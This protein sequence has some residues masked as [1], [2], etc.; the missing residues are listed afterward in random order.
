MSTGQYSEAFSQLE[1]LLDLEP[2]IKLANFYLAKLALIEKNF[3][4]ARK[5][6]HQE[7]KLNKDL[8]IGLEYAGF[9]Q[10][11]GEKKESEMI[12]DELRKNFPDRTLI[13]SRPQAANGVEP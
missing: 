4:A 6:Y 5:Y 11:Q 1:I 13:V 9:L 10:E 2:N 8:S 3:A 7:F 12:L